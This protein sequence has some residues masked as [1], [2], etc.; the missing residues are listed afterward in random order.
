MASLNL[1]MFVDFGDEDNLERYDVL[2]LELEVR[3]EAEL[4][5]RR[6]TKKK[7]GK[8]RWDMERK[9]IYATRTRR[10]I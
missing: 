10:A 8:M 3:K 9:T 4:D 2:Q 1:R 7:K 6:S 5:T